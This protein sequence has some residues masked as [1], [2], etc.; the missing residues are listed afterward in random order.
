MTY[1]FAP[2]RFSAATITAETVFPSAVARAWAACQISSETRTARSG[3]FGWLGICPSPPGRRSVVALV[4]GVAGAVCDLA[5]R[6][7]VGE[8]TTGSR[9]AQAADPRRGARGVAAL[10]AWPRVHRVAPSAGC[11]YI[12]ARGVNTPVLS[13]TA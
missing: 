4:I 8:F 9:R 3:V 12:L 1:F 11:R 5:Q 2:Y 7:G 10:S 6:E 13:V